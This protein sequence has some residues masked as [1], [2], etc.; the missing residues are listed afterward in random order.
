M[1]YLPTLEIKG[2]EDTVVQV[3]DEYLREIVYTL[4]INGTTWRPKV[5]KEG[6]YTIRVGEGDS[7]KVFRGVES[8]A[9]DD[10]RKLVVEF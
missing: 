7:A 9:A 10:D 1:A 4:R 3:I 6:T 2:R 8:T 5:F